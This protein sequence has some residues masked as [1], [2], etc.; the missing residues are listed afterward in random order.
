MNQEIEDYFDKFGATFSFIL[1]MDI[2]D[3]NQE[4]VLA[5]IDQA[6]EGKRG[7][8]FNDDLSGM[9]EGAVI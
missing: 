9:P 5:L 8:I 1:F 7:A 4:R 3:T 6:M 2:S